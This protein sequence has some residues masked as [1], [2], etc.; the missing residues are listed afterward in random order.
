MSYEE[1]LEI[2]KNTPITD[3]QIKDLRE[4]LEEQCRRRDNCVTSELLNRTYSI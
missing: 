1:L 4:E 2:V 3:D